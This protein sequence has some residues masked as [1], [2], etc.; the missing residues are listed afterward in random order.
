MV[1]RRS[2]HS[3]ARLASWLKERFLLRLHMF[4]ILTG[5]F[6]AGLLATFSLLLLDVQTLWL[7]YSISVVVAY[8]AFLALIRLWLWYIGVAARP[9]PEDPAAEDVLELFS[10]LRGN[11]AD[12]PVGGGGEFGGGGATGSWGDAASSG[13]ATVNA[14]VSDL[15]GC[16][17]F[18]E[19]VLVVI[20]V[21]VLLSFAFAGVYVIWMAPAILAEAVFE[22]ALAAALTRRARRIDR[23][24]WVGHVWRAT[25]LPFLSVL[26]L[27]IVIGALA[28]SHCPSATRLREVVDCLRS[29]D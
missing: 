26:I 29:S 25:F 19:G 28:E 22:A 10:H 5:A 13:D 23:P 20:A 4:W 9:E 18:D 8:A 15:P 6:L 11:V 21:A 24:G 14:D 1:G 2:S 3:K 12:V 27:A 17:D 16:L 7:R